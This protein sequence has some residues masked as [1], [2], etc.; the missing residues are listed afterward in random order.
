MAAKGRSKNKSKVVKAVDASEDVDLDAMERMLNDSDSEVDSGEESSQDDS[1]VVDDDESVEQHDSE[2]EEDDDQVDDDSDEDEDLPA[3]ID[4]IVG[5]ET[6]NIDLRNLLAFNTHQVNHKILYKK[7]QKGDDCEPTILVDGTKIANE[8][9]L[10]QKSSECC[11][12][13]LSELWK[14]DTVKTDVGP[15][16][17]LPSYFKTVTPRELVSIKLIVIRNFLMRYRELIASS[18]P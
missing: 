1:V 17:I 5:D 12:Q 4:E 10:L 3:N 6:C 14:L 8:D 18:N 7:K 15:M 2:G 16:A 9:F 11:T 13:L